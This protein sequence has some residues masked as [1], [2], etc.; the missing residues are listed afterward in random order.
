MSR[1]YTDKEEREFYSSRWCPKRWEQGLKAAIVFGAQR[2]GKIM[3]P[4]KAGD[5]CRLGAHKGDFSLS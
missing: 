4:E 3:V 5:V 1:S 2:A